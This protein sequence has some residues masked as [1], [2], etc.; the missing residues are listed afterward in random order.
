M[1]PPLRR[2]LTLS[3]AALTTSFA[4]GLNAAPDC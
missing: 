3:N 4:I 2:I 1:P